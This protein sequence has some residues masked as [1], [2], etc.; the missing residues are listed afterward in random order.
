[1]AP[2]NT[3]SKQIV[4]TRNRKKEEKNSHLTRTYKCEKCNFPF[5]AAANNDD[6]DDLCHDNKTVMIDDDVNSS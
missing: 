3:S 5:S 4:K 6:G 1:M 2:K